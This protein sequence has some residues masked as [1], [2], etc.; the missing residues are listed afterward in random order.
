MNQAPQITLSKHIIYLNTTLII[1]D[2]VYKITGFRT[3]DTRYLH[4]VL[5]LKSTSKRDVIIEILGDTGVPVKHGDIVTVVL[6]KED[7]EDPMPIT[8]AY[9]RSGNMEC[10]GRLDLSKFNP[11]LNTIALVDYII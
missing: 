10:Q 5:A 9:S 1:D 2:Y 6:E 8:T 3:P 11:T 4:L 7:E